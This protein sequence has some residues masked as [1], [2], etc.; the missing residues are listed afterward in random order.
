MV[1]TKVKTGD[2]NPV[3]RTSTKYEKKFP[4]E[5][6]EG[7]YNQIVNSL[8]SSWDLRTDWGMELVGKLKDLAIDEANKIVTEEVQ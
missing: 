7:D 8:P 5:S 3:N 2:E 4:D 1:E 6:F